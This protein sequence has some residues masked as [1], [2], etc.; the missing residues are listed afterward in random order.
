MYNDFVQFVR[1]IYN[2][3]D[4]INLHTPVFN[5]N[6][7]K[8]LVECIDSTFVSSVGQFVNDF[9]KK[10]AEYTGAKYAVVTASGTAALHT[11][12]LIADVKVNELVITQPLSFIATC[13]AIS[14][15]GAQ[16][17]F[18]DIDLDTLGLSPVALQKF[19]DAE[20]ETKNGECIHKKT[21]KKVSACVP[22]HTFGFPCKIDEIA[23]IWITFPDPF[24]R[25]SRSNHRLTSM[26]FLNLYK[27]IVKTG[28]PIHLKTDEP[29]LYAYTLE[30]VTEVAGWGALVRLKFAGAATLA[31]L[32]A[33]T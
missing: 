15:I 23:E 26:R 22:M 7:K 8:Y 17:V 11:A 12:L 31:T 1:S 18:V 28:N 32:A 21:G 10:L 6:E 33:T 19:L 20:C 30:T 4:P 27:Q 9:E 29:N 16:P 5:G 25:K 2:T 14:Y 3:N 24:L 13:N